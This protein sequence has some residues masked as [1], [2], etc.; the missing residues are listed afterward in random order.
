MKCRMIGHPRARCRCEARRL[1][2]RLPLCALLG[3]GAASWVTVY[4]RATRC[5]ATSALL[6]ELKNLKDVLNIRAA[7]AA[8]RTDLVITP[9][10][11]SESKSLNRRGRAQTIERC[12]KHESV[13]HC[14]ATHCFTVTCESAI[15]S[16]T[17]TGATFA[18]A[19]G[20]L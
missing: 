1:G 9:A 10:Q 20:K 4:P 3:T 19:Q 13:S 14:G 15:T 16:S 2:A 17:G 7:R 6:E 11:Y 8:P 12:A 18:N 5:F